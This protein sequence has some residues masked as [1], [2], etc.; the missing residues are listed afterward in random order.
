MSDFNEEDVWRDNL[1]CSVQT[2]F[3]YSH[4]IQTTFNFHRVGWVFFPLFCIVFPLLVFLLWYLSSS[5]NS[6]LVPDKHLFLSAV[7]NTSLSWRHKTSHWCISATFSPSQKL[8]CIILML[9]FPLSYFICNLLWEKHCLSEMQVPSPRRCHR[10]THTHFLPSLSL[11]SYSLCRWSSFLKI[12]T[13][14]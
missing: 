3:Y 7:R 11:Q 13:Y 8:L 1:E 12:L 2:T 9:H 5:Q 6:D 10:R 4:S 14:V